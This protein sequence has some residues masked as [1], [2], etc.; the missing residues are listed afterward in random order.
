MEF[1]Y[2]SLPEASKVTPYIQVADLHEGVSVIY[3]LL[4]QG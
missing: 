1:H 4:K 2:K 3:P